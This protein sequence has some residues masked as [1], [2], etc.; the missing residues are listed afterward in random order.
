[1]YVFTLNIVDIC[2]YFSIQLLFF[3]TY[4]IFLYIYIYIY[5]DIYCYLG[6]V[7]YEGGGGVNGEQRHIFFSFLYTCDGHMFKKIPYSLSH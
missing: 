3:L 5:K 2:K 6:R 4:H 7:Y 1:M